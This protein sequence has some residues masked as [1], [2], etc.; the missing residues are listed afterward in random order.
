MKRWPTKPLLDV[1]K[2]TRGNEPGSES[3]VASPAGTRFLRVGDI[4]G[5]TDNP[6]YT[7]ARNLVCVTEGDLLLALDGTPGQVSTGHQGAISSGI[8]KVE[9]LDKRILTLGWLRYS[10]NSPD[11]QVTI[12]QHTRGVTILHASSALPHISIP[13]PPLTEQE[14]V[15]NL[16]D[17]A[18]AL[19]KLRTQAGDRTTFLIPAIFHEMFGD[20]HELPTATVAELAEQRPQSP[21]ALLEIPGIGLAKAERYGVALLELISEA[22]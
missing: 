7:N 13:L 11:V 14:R 21:R 19:R 12:K 16:L 22:A 6:V 15:V 3:Y 2:L 18:D 10:L 5:K 9:V 1:A 20:Q 8:R 4:T 17:E